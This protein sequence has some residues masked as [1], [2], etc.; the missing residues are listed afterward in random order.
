MMP[1]KFERRASAACEAISYSLQMGARL[2]T[3]SWGFTSESE[4]LKLAIEKAEKAGQLFVAAVDNAGR[5][6]AK[7]VICKV[8]CVAPR[9][10]TDL[11]SKN[12]GGRLLW[13]AASAAS[14]LTARL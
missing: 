6:N 9:A 13:L 12:K 2:S 4:A 7:C 14:G 5:N 10:A 3:N 11:R 1:L 8:L